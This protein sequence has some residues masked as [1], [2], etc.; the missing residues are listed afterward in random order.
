MYRLNAVTIE[1]PPLRER[2]EDIPLLADH[3]VKKMNLSDTQTLSFSPETIKILG[4]HEWK[5]NVRELENTVLHAASIS[6]GTIYPEH[7]YRRMLNRV[8]HGSEVQFNFRFD[9]AEHLRLF[10]M[11]ITL[12]KQDEILFEVRIIKENPRLPQSPFENKSRQI[13]EMLI[14]CSWCD[15]INALTTIGRKLKRR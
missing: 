13:D 3:F 10:E 1:L 14:I 11:N 4:N 2:I 15:R 9:S 8:R 7:L 12:Q 5:G 6:N